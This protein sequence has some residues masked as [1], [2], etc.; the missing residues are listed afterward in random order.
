MKMMK[1]KLIGIAL[2]CSALSSVAMARSPM[3]NQLDEMKSAGLPVDIAAYEREASYER[4]KLNFD[5]RAN[6]ESQKLVE[7]IRLRVIEAYESGLKFHN[8][9]QAA[10]DEVVMAIS[11]DTELAASGLKSELRRLSIEILD[12]HIR[13]D[14][15]YEVTANQSGLK[16][17]FKDQS[18]LRASMLQHQEEVSMAANG[19]GD[20]N[21]KQREFDSKAALIKSLTS[22]KANSPYP[23]SSIVSINSAKQYSSAQSISAQVSMEFLGVSVSAGPTI[24][25]K[26]TYSS[27]VVIMAIGLYPVLLQD[28]NFDLYQRDSKNKIVK[29]KGVD[30]RREISFRCQAQVNF[31]SDYKGAGG[32]KVMGM[33]ADVSVTQSYSNSVSI[34]SRRIS[35]PDYVGGKS[36]TMAFLSNLCQNDF[37]NANITNG[38]TVKSNLD[39]MMRTVISSLTFSHPKTKCATDNDCI[40]WYNNEVIS[41]HKTRTYPRCL[42]EASGREKFFSCGLRGLT[43][44]NCTLY[45]DGK[46]TT[47]GSFEYV[48]D[49]G[50]KCQKTKEGGWFTRGEIKAYDEA[51]CTPVNNKTYVSPLESDYIEIHFAN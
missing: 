41:W 1:S 11:K 16:A 23:S 44:A 47:D 18:L 8:D 28:G 32:F 48:C 50:L 21:G 22:T 45:K 42:Q 46:R 3:L 31:S 37:L 15:G 7:T 34:D 30:Q 4:A 13:G 29:K 6:L 51:K 33:G 35:L 10:R 17:Y 24:S 38:R 26:R 2:A 19:D 14:A 36:V 12:A 9:S 39:G 40:D 25:F 27:D 20:D 43:N 5:E 49:K